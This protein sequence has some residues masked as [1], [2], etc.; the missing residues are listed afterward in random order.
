M[1]CPVCKTEYTPTITV[2]SHCGFPELG[3]TF[4]S[5]EEAALWER[6]T[7]VPCRTIFTH[8]TNEKV[9]MMEDELI[10]ALQTATEYKEKAIR[11]KKMLDQSINTA[12][13]YKRVAKEFEELAKQWERKCMEAKNER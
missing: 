11:L 2:C 8:M 12:K 6:T 5:T 1:K 3:R 10:P 13:E 9:R 7:V 4:V